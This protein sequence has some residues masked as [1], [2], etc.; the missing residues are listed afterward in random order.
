VQHLQLLFYG[1]LLST[2]FAGITVLSILFFRTRQRVLLL[3]LAVIVLYSLGLMLFVL[4]FY[5]REIIAYPVSFDQALSYVN[6]VLTVG[7]YGTIIAVAFTVAPNTP[8]AVLI[9]SAAPV[10]LVYALFG[11]VAWSVA[12]L[13]GW[14]RAHSTLVSAVSAIAASIFLAYAGRVITGGGRRLRSAPV[15]FFIV[16]VGRILFW[17]AVASTTATLIT[18]AA[19]W[20][21]DLVS[22]LNFVLYLAW[23]VISIVAFVRYL[24]LPVNLLA[25]GELPPETSARFGISR[26]EAE[27]IALVAEGRSNKEI[28]DELNISF[29]TARTHLYNI[30]RKTGAASRVELLRLVSRK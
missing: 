18:W 16:Q 2:G 14:V 13:S 11:V 10:A 9:A 21:V 29:T 5:V 8:R 27:V 25:N 22:T 30:F 26:R 1:L 24:L 19:G 15:R 6:T 20:S 7:V 12:P 4:A 23:N 28:A 17:F 3:S